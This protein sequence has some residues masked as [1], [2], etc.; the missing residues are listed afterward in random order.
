V[1]LPGTAPAAI[2]VAQEGVWV[3]S[4]E[5]GDLNLVDPTAGTVL[6][7]NHV[8]GFGSHLAVL[9]G[10]RLA[11]GRFDTGGLGSYVLVV[12]PAAESGM[13]FGT[14]PVGALTVD[15][16]GY[17]YALEKG[18]HLLR[19]DKATFAEV[20]SARV[21]VDDEHMEVVIADGAAWVSSDHTPIRR[22]SVDDMTV[23][24]TID[25]GGGIPF[26]VA[27]GRIW[28]ARPGT[29]WVLDPATKIVTR[30]IP[31]P[32]VD[33]ILGM[34][35]DSA[36]S[37]AWLAVRLP[38][39]VGAVLRMDLTTG[40]FTGTSPVSLPAAVRIVGPAIYVASYLDNELLVY[41]L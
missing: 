17:V 13:G 34:D 28:G 27:D 9:P 40:A 5:S 24:D 4:V 18:G 12:D 11:V 16:E 38:G 21:E 6:R 10:G 33:E 30:E 25:V 32:G 37:E 14:H 8:G 3:Y 19:L 7:T 41:R 2:A 1:A 36:S 23:T 35:V 26:V 20:G 15:D 29:M 39:R 22:V 31:M